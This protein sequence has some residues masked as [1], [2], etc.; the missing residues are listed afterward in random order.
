MSVK[1]KVLLVGSLPPPVHGSNIYFQNLLNSEIRN[2]FDITHLDISDHRDLKNL[3]KL[4]LTNVTLALNSITELRKKLIDVKPDLVYIP[5]A[6][7]FLPYLRDGLFILVSSYFSNAKVIIH[8]HEG[9]N[10][11]KGFYE[12]S[13][14]P[15]KYFIKK[16]L[17]KVD[18]SI[19]LGERLRNVFSEFVKNVEVVPNGIEREEI[20][21]NVTEHP[22]NRT[23]NNIQ[24]GFLGNLFESKGVIDL[25]NAAIIVLGKHPDT[26][27]IIAG[28]SPSREQ[29]ALE[30]AERIISK[31][32]L[33]DNFIFPGVI[34]GNAKKEFFT[35]TDIFVFPS[36]YRYEGLPLVILAAMSSSIPVV[37]VKETG[38][39]AD[40]VAE[41]ETGILTEKKNPQETADAIIYLI[42]NPD[43]R[44]EMGRKGKEKFEK[45]FTLKTNINN[46]IRVFNKVLN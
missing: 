37:S 24:I 4:D 43:I 8:S 19:V 35:D 41:N 17:G 27:F 45:E 44:I 11:R 30:E 9:D 22:R 21:L 23:S 29:S 46:I 28:G 1:K 20:D 34:T 38:V 18:T 42:E 2:E 16:S 12:G 7:N 5:V 13:S 6:S 3:S 14:F 31:H 33:Q 40:I 25:V 26:K 39:I 36:W 32:G 10:F 15:V